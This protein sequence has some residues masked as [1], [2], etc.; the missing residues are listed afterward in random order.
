MLAM[1]MVLLA[2]IFLAS[3]AEASEDR[4]SREEKKPETDMDASPSETKA[5]RGRNLFGGGGRRRP[6]RTKQA[7]NRYVIILVQFFLD[8]FE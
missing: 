1:I 6:G 8:N 2:A 5:R 3:V 7:L 4:S